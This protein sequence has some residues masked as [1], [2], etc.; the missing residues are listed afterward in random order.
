[1]KINVT[2]S[3]MPPFEEYVEEIKD[4]W[5]SRFL[6]NNGPKH[7]KLEEA[8]KKYFGVENVILFTN[9]HLALEFM[10]EGLDLTG[11][12][13]TTPFTFASTTTSLY[14]KGITPVFCDINPKDYTIDCNK[15]EAL[16]TEKTTAIMPVH[17][18]GKLCDDE[19][20]KKIADKYGLKVIYDAAHAFGVFKN[21]ISSAALGDASMFSFHATKVFNTIEG[22]C[23]ATNNKELASK[24]NTL[25][26][27][28]LDA[29]ANCIYA[30][31][32]G[33]MS[34][35]QAAM[36][37]C[38]L[39]YL[40][41]EINL[42]REAAEEYINCLKGTEG[43]KLPPIQE[44]V[45]DNY[46]YFPVVFEN[47]KYNRDEVASRLADNDI[48]ARKYFYPT[49]NSFTCFAHLEQQNTTPVAS[50]IAENVL[51][52]PLYAGLSREDVQ[53]ICKIILN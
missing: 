53:E 28:G 12:V 23:V 42:R 2:R 21:G 48:G 37:L 7:Q 6:T 39:K 52:L 8:L 10:I 45:K 14:R 43:I 4:I 18:Y 15:I 38:N 5:D 9:G 40:D 1:M 29:N 51:T 17:V 22:G 20:I 24:L 11:E 33:K 34:E 25:K 35:F 27:F 36:G 26:N 44:A 31:G 41:R 19:K 47:Y 49:V 50:K 13:I 46:S 3:S 32:N 16:I 30:G